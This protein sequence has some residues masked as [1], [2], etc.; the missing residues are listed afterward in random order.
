[1]ENHQTNRDIAKNHKIMN[2]GLDARLAYNMIKDQLILDGNAKQNLATFVTTYMEP[3]AAKL[4]GEVANKNMIDKDEYPQTAE[5]ENRC[6]E[7]IA[8]LWNVPNIDNMIGCSTTRSSEACMLAG[9]AMKRKMQLKRKNKNFKPNLITGINTQICWE[10]F[11]N[12][13]DVEMRQ[14]PLEKG[15]YIID[16][17]EAVKLCDE[18]T[19]GVVGIL[20]STFTGEYEPIEKLNKE[21]DKFNKKHNLEIPIHVDA[22]SGGFVAPFLQKILKWDFRL[23]WVKSINVSGHKFGLVYP[24]VGWAIWKDKKDLPEDLVFNVNYLGGKMPTFTLNFSKSASQVIGQYYNFVRLGFEGYKKVHEESREIANNIAKNL[25]KYEIFDIISEGNDIA[26]VSWKVKDK[27]D[28]NLFLLSERLNYT[29]WQVPAYTLPDN[30]TDV[31]V[32]RIVIREGFSY[33]MADLLLKDLEKAIEYCKENSKHLKH[34]KKHC[35]KH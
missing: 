11:C 28:F 5:I 8:R 6:V 22:A 35:Y 3:E 23:K 18:N 27:V 30:L 19:I 20:G 25:K 13:W 24:G 26:V 31:V 1:M 33:E 10:K 34:T 21:I 17:I 29:G 14:V 16:P 4:M 2:K 9:L 12:Y 7:I 15:R 32:M